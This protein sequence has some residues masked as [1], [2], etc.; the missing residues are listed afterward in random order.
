MSS[1]DFSRFDSLKLFMHQ[2]Y[3]YRKGV[4][5]LVLCTMCND[6]AQIMCKRLDEQG[7]SYIEQ[8]VSSNKVNLYF[9][10]EA[11]LD[12]VRTFVHKPM[13]VLTPAEDFMLG[14][15]SGMTSRRSA[16]ASANEVKL[17]AVRRIT[18]TISLMRLFEY[19]FLLISSQKNCLFVI[20]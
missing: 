11:C 8:P 20:L 4:R 15:C 16:N 2:I 10:K 12:V 13:H 7:I 14:A 1:E 18:P 19:L 6:C 3:E 17:Y 5:P 9:G